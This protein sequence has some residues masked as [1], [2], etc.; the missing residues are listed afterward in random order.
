MESEACGNGNGKFSGKIL[1]KNVV[2]GEDKGDPRFQVL[3]NVDSGIELRCRK[4]FCDLDHQVSFN[5]CESILDKIFSLG[6]DNP[7]YLFPLISSSSGD[8]LYL[9]AP[10]QI[11]YLSPGMVVADLTVSSGSDHKWQHMVLCYSK[12][13]HND[14][15]F[16]GKQLFKYEMMVHAD[17]RDVDR[18]NSGDFSLGLVT[19]MSRHYNHSFHPQPYKHLDSHLL[20]F[21]SKDLME[22]NL[23]K[24]SEISDSD[25]CGFYWWEHVT[26]LHKDLFESATFR[27]DK[28]PLRKPNVLV[29]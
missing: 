10:S 21:P 17:Q 11:E 25:G 19:K 29:R 27:H 6:D 15:F 16:Q 18:I 23:N 8:F 26:P 24:L 14:K 3:K 2:V 13:F 5:N 22:Y 7:N 20:G 1:L 28:Y 12:T 9:L 4:R